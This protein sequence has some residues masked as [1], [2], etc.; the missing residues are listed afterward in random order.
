MAQDAEALKARV[1]LLRK[2]R[3]GEKHKVE[4]GSSNDPAPLA[5]VP[6]TKEPPASLSPPPVVFVPS[7]SSPQ[8][9]LTTVPQGTLFSPLK[10]LLSKL[11]PRHLLHQ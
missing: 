3:S 5:K 7:P 1:A 2:I 6:R 10:G 9:A 8:I 4:V 11:G